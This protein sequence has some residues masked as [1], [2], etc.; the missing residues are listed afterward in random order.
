MSLELTKMLNIKLIKY[1]NVKSLLVCKI[2]YKK[3]HNT[4]TK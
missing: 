3:L 4:N 2:N 1:F